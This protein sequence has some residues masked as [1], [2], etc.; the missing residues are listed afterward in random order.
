MILK[1]YYINKDISYQFSFAIQ[2]LA[3]DWSLVQHYNLYLT[4]P[5]LTAIENSKIPHLGFLYVVVYQKEVPVGLMYFQSIEITNGFY[6]QDTFPHEIKKRITTKMLK[7]LCGNLMVC[8]NFFAT[9]ENGFVMHQEISTEV[10]YEVVKDLKT[11]LKQTG[12]SIGLSFILFKEFWKNQQLAIQQTLHKKYHSFEIDV[13]MVLE[14][15]NTWHTFQEYL[16]SMTTKYRTRAKSVYKKTIEIKERELSAADIKAAKSSIHNLYVSVVKTASFNMV[17]FT[18]DNFYQFK[19]ELKDDFVFRG[20]FLEDTLVAF[21]TACLTDGCL[22]ANYVGIDYKINESLPLYQR[23]LYDY[24]QLAITNKVKELRLGRTAELIKSS[25]GAK[26]V[27]MQLYIKHNNK[28][29]NTLMKPLIK[30]VKPSV[31]E[32]RSPFKKD[33]KA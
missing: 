15:D 10:V 27:R 20:Y 7:S 2:D 9:G 28:M 16:S 5:Y 33:Q 21:S 24:V 30:K 14:M 26:P 4:T 11:A 19:K 1:P 29:V 18:E 25:L 22:D 17:K 32:L 31:Y 8:G 13:N 6:F 3:K 12:T 23:I